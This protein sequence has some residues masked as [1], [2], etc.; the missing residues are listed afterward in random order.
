MSFKAY[1]LPYWACHNLVHN[2]PGCS[3]A[4][5]CCHTATTYVEMQLV[6]TT[7][8]T[9]ERQH[10][11]MSFDSS[12]EVLQCQCLLHTMVTALQA[13]AESSVTVRSFCRR[14]ASG[15]VCAQTCWALLWLLSRLLLLPR[16]A[17]FHVTQC[18]I[19]KFR[20]TCE[21]FAYTNDREDKGKGILPPCFGTLSDRLSS[22]AALWNRA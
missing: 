3:P 13:P 20:P 6:T 1:R 11:T 2:Q 7:A 12:S 18:L 22:A 4:D 9:A 14:F 10:H 21:Q 19:F 15:I 16:P 5:I 8:H 17:S